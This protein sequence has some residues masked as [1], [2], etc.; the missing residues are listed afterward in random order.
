MSE[1]KFWTKVGEIRTHVRNGLDISHLSM[2]VASVRQNT[3]KDF[4][5]QKV[6]LPKAYLSSF[7]TTKR[8]GPDVLKR[9]ITH[10][11]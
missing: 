2:I 1:A 8:T 11:F 6:S 3:K 7:S 9:K 10:Q 4:F 5:F